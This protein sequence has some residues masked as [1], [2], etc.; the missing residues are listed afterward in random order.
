M[1]RQVCTQRPGCSRALKYLP[2]EL[3]NAAASS[4]YRE[5]EIQ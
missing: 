2:S 4:K 5:I 1:V 3:N